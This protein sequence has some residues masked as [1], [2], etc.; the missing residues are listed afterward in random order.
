VVTAGNSFCNQNPI[1]VSL[2]VGLNVREKRV[3]S[4]VAKLVDANARQLDVWIKG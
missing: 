1:I 2:V 3:H 4:Q